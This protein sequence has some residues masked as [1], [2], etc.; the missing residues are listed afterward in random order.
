M[1]N[2]QP[3]WD[4][5]DLEDHDTL[6]HDP[7]YLNCPECLA[8]IDIPGIENGQISQCDECGKHWMLEVTTR[9]AEGS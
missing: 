7:D 8:Q 3:F 2:E 5:F 1:T 6:D 9:L 4:E